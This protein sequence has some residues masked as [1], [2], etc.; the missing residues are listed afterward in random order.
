MNRCAAR[1]HRGLRSGPRVY[2]A[3]TAAI[4]ALLSAC[5]ASVPVPKTGPHT[6]EEP[7]LVPYPP[8]PARVEVIPS[9]PPNLKDPVWIDGEWQ[10]KG[11]RWVWQPGQWELPYADGYYALPTTVRL[12]DGTLVYYPGDWK[13]PRK[14]Q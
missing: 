2:L 7:V 4:A 5:G 1:C 13:A 12:A 8:P 6:N 3:F 14:E 10:W 11:R 9:P